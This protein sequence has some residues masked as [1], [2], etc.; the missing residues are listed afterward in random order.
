MF[1]VVEAYDT[2]CIYS[3][4]H[5]Q[6]VTVVSRIGKNSKISAAKSSWLV[7]YK[8]SYIFTHVVCVTL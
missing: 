3:S 4:D 2:G 8:Y 5:Y 1:V 7:Y 6:H